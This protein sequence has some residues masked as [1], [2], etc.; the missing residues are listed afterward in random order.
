MN[1]A[2]I[3]L[4][5]LARLTVALCRGRAGPQDFPHAPRLL[6]GLFMGGLL[7]DLLIG[8]LLGVGDALARSLLAGAI[9][10]GLCWVALAIRHVRNRYMQTASAL[11]AC[12]VA[13]S[14]LQ[15]PLALLLGPV[16]AT[17]PWSASQVALGWITLGLLAW[18]LVVDAHIMRHAIEGSTGVA[19]ALVLSWLVADWALERVIFGG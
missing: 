19:F 14:L 12:S 1:V 6:A 15:L 10:L 4:A 13:F 16:P 2:P 8:S 3:S 7:L 9:V 17:A 11:L 5:Q 18:Q